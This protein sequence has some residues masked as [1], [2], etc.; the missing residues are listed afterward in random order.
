VGK[1]WVK[2][3][4][5]GGAVALALVGGGAV[6]FAQTQS[7]APN[8]AFQSFLDD[9]ASH[10]GVTPAALQSAI[11]QAEIDRVNQAVQSGKL[12]QQQAQNIE[13]RIQSGNLRWG[14]LFGHMGHMRRPGRMGMGGRLLD[15]AATYL[16]ITP[17]QLRTQLASGKTLAQIADS[18]SGK[19]SQ[20]LQ[21][22][23]LS[24]IQ[25]RLDAAVKSGRITQAQET[26]MLQKAQTRI[27]DLMNRQFQFHKWNGKPGTAPNP[28]NTATPSTSASGA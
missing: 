7:T 24:Q 14:P 1:T 15:N 27:G 16:G 4:M 23:L 28:N 3:A 19:S 6:A 25:T 8:N 21:Q 11:Q 13:G 20:G 2:R 22:Y 12:T 10:L 9:V 5:V 18:T 17:Q 26:Q